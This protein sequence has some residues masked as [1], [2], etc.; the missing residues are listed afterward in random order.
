VHGVEVMDV[1]DDPGSALEQL[2]DDG[3]DARDDVGSMIPAR[4]ALRCRA[5]RR[6]CCPG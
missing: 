4:P 1:E 3:V 6:A 2:A 5:V